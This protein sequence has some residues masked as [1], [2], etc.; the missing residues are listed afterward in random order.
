MTKHTLGHRRVRSL[1]WSLALLLLA[2]LPASAQLPSG[3]ILGV[4]RDT[5]GAT[6]P[7]AKVSVLNV[8]T[9][10]ARTATTGGDGAFRVS[11]LQPG[12]YSVTVE[13]TGFKT[14]T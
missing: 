10:D 13:K 4:V 9:N 2:A 7:E 11:A 8:D 14:Q 12:H 3:T 6:V 1:S 5:T